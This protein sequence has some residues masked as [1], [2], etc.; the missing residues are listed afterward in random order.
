MRVPRLRGRHVELRPLVRSDGAA[1]GRVLHDRQVTR[2]LPYRVRHETGEAWVARILLGQRRGDGVAFAICPPGEPGAVGQIRLFRWSLHD[3]Q[4]EVGYWI[5]RSHW[6]RGFGSDSLRLVCAFG[7][8]EMRLHRIVAT[9]VAE[10]ERSLRALERVGFRR[11]GVARRSASLADGW[12]D[13][14]TLG[15]LRGE[16]LARTDSG[17]L[18]RTRH[19][20]G[21]R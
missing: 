21:S 3:R 4:A 16:L 17:P 9:V 10:N 6:G 19:A 5:R 8:R 1:L 2:S 15:L 13:E 12:S 7:F 14:V 18:G 11:E 20:P